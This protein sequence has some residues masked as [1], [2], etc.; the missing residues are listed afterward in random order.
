M[1]VSDPL[2]LL[3]QVID[4]ALKSGAESADAVCFQ[5][6]SLSQAQRQ[7]QLETLERAESADLGLRVLIGRRQAIVSSSD[8][9]E[10]AL[11]EL[12]SRAVAMAKVVPEDEYCGLAEPSQIVRSPATIDLAD[13]EE[14]ADSVLADRAAAAEDAARAVEGVTN[15]EGAEASW[16]R[17]VI[18]LAAS[19]GFAGSYETTMHS[20]SASVLAGS[21][22]E[23]ERDYDFSSSRYG[24]DLE[25]PVVIGRNAG[26][27]AVRR[28]GPIKP[29]TGKLPVVYDPRVAN[30]LIGSFAGAINGSSVARGTSFLK[31]AMGE[32]LLPKGVRLIDDPLRARGLRSRP[33]DGEGLEARRLAIVE[34]GVLKTWI[35]DL[36]TARQLGLESTGRGSRGTSSPPSPSTTNLYLE[37]GELSPAELISDIEEGVYITE[38][39]GMGVN[40]VTGDY[41]QGAAGFRIEKGELTKPI[42]EF[43]V[44]SN[45]KDMFRDLKVANDL[46]FR[47]GTNAPTLRIDRMTVAGD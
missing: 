32:Q 10:K 13:P 27:K 47:Y 38:T 14:P 12:V 25:D 3:D 22:T 19:N 20:I 43:T 44:A 11:T 39:M 2:N 33:F 18:A 37:P 26:E 9:T 16:S 29:K 36:R 40:G 15:S 42:S 23:M 28:L 21:G 6:I 45:L 4:K 1:A 24:A 30:R 46:V 41:S 17:S 8:V 5:G 7:G 34:D 35:L 31:D